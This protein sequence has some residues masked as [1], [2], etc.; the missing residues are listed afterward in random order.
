MESSQPRSIAEIS[1]GLRP[2]GT[3]QGE[4]GRIRPSVDNPPVRARL[5]R[6]DSLRYVKGILTYPSLYLAAQRRTA[7]L[8]VSTV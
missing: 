3:G 6:A 5:G 8:D 1:F 2:G 4:V 7:P